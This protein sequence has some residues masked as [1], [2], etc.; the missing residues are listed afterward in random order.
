MEALT[1]ELEHT[2]QKVHSLNI[3]VGHFVE[4]LWGEV[5]RRCSTRETYLLLKARVSGSP[6]LTRLEE[7]DQVLDE[8]SRLVDINEESS[9]VK[10]ESLQ[11][12]LKAL[13]DQ[14]RKLK[15]DIQK[16]LEEAE[17]LDEENEHLRRAAL[18]EGTPRWC[19]KDLQEASARIVELQAQLRLARQEREVVDKVSPHRK[20]PVVLRSITARMTDTEL[21]KTVQSL[22]PT[23]GG[24]QSP[25]LQTEVYKFID[26]CRLA[27]RG[28]A[29]EKLRIFLEV[30]K[31]RLYGDAYQ[32]VRL[33]EFGSVEELVSII[34]STYLR[35]RTLDS[36]MRELY[37]A[38]QRCDED[39]RQFARRLQA[40][41]STAEAIIKD[42]YKGRTDDVMLA[43]INKRLKATFTS[44][45]RE[46]M[47]RGR[48]LASAAT[49]LDGLLEEALV[50]Q[51]TLWRGEE[52]PVDKIRY[53]DLDRRPYA[54]HGAE[55]SGND[56]M[57]ALVAAVHQL[58]KKSEE[59][60]GAATAVEPRTTEQT[61]RRP[62][63][64]FCNRIG[65]TRDDCWTRKNTPYCAQCQQYGHEESHRCRSNVEQASA[66]N[67]AGKYKSFKCFGCGEP[68]HRRADC[69]QGH[70]ASGNGTGPRRDRAEN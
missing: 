38:G 66:G 46:P 70:N 29:S 9:Q 28:V 64:S 61:N 62:R 27:S 11:A 57:S 35:T 40:L 50:A 17:K 69:P 47:I 41:A 25:S 22:V 53:N 4:K 30:V 51:A 26:G 60:Q 68:G 43:E 48:M 42:A 6:P 54:E 37:E 10:I 14:N 36:V 12:E 31:Q 24:E 49:T 2:R 63:C 19:F 52:P 23:F 56:Q 8:L 20:T 65:H 55:H 13:G 18:G 45:L 3:Q 44:G 16:N 33:R 59:R 39:I 32:L 21:V 15:K 67:A 1:A 7:A 5:E 34:K 58:L